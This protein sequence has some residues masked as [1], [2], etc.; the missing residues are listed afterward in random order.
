MSENNVPEPD[1]SGGDN[2]LVSVIVPMRNEEGWIERCVGSILAQ[3]YPS[4]CMEVIVVDGRSDDRSLEI[5]GEIAERDSRLRVL[6]NPALIVPSSLNLA[7][8]EARGAIIA[9]V[10]AHTVLDPEYLGAGVELLTRTGADNVGGPMVS[11]GGG[12][13]GDAIAE[14]MASRFG[15]G[16]VFHFATEE[17]EC[18]TV[19]MGM[20][21]RRVFETVGLFDEQLVRN[22]DDEHSCRI[23]KAGGRIL[24]SPALRSRYQN[25]QSW[26][27]LLTQFFQYG[28]WKVRVLQ[29][30]PAQMS[31][32]HFVPPAMIALMLAA[33]GFAAWWPRIA[34]LI[35]GGYALYLTGMFVVA[36][37]AGGAPAAIVRRFAAML[38]IHHA[39]GTGFL[40]GLVR[41]VANWLLPESR[42]AR[43]EP[44]ES[45]HV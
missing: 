18:D 8:A 17:R 2:P 40:A 5:L 21:P 34:S 6:S 4:E 7:L 44:R 27:E 13:V 30:H 38:I 36:A 31:V 22:Q 39:W 19:Y 45:A 42:P 16:A 20:W 37:S 41:F 28:F 26:K 32:R 9:R 24:V 33:V 35:G 11:L 25:R 12:P 15:I 10:D 3:N 29:K 23:R 43:L 1:T 14:A